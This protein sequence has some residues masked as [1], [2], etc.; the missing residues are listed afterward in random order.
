MV[1]PLTGHTLGYIT[2]HVATCSYDFIMLC[3]CGNILA[4]F[5]F[6]KFSSPAWP[7]TPKFW[8]Y[9]GGQKSR[10]PPLILGCKRGSLMRGFQSRLKIEIGWNLS[11]FFR[12]SFL[13]KN[14]VK[15]YPISILRPDLEFLQQGASFRP[16]NERKG[17][18]LFLTPIVISKLLLPGAGWGWKF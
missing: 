11:L 13:P 10:N 3:I 14:G 2:Y 8:N 12:Q 18:T 4:F 16:R 5:I 6:L 17:Y 7:W 1:R 15:C 9:N